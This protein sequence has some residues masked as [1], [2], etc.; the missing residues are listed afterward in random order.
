VVP[1]C[2]FDNEIAVLNYERIG[3]ANDSTTS[4]TRPRVKRTFDM[5]RIAA[6]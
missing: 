6:T 4:F 3:N 2:K 1:G 5:G